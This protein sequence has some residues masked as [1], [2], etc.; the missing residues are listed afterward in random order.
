LWEE[1]EMKLAL[2][3]VFVLAVCILWPAEASLAQ[4]PEEPNDNG[5]CDTLYTEVHPPDAE[6]TGAG[7]LV[8]VPIRVTNDISDAAIDSIAAWCIPLCYTHTNPT[9]YCSLSSWWN[10]TTLWEW[11]PDADRS[12]FRHLD[13][14]I[15]WYIA[16]DFFYPP[17]VI[18]DLDGTSHFW[19][20]LFPTGSA[21]KRWPG[22]SRRLLLTMTY[23]VEDSV[24]VSMDSCFW[25]PS[26]NLSF[27]RSDAVRYV[28]RGNM[29]YS[30]S[31]F[32]PQV[33][34]ANGDGIIDGG[35][36]VF[37][38]NYLFREGPEPAPLWVA[39]VNCLQG[40]NV[41]DIV[42]LVSYLYCGGPEPCQH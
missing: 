13:D 11:A 34:D 42:Y 1:E 10:T 27:L 17:T 14:E 7:H 36:V 5:L 35:D 8:R 20:T 39:D 25:P 30:F 22:G 15:N 21:D 6:F 3:F 37:L 26:D 9:K 40:V 28:P 38:G 2:L 41:G 4:C 32:Y 12:I 33:G 23:K 24:T 16:Q 29:P 31:V 19:F 18:L